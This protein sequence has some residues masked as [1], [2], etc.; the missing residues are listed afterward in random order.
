MRLFTSICL[1][2]ALISTA[3]VIADEDLS[4][5]C[6]NGMTTSY[7]SPT[8][9]CGCASSFSNARK[10][11]SDAV[12][13]KAPTNGRVGCKNKA[14]GSECAA[15]C[16]ETFQPSAD[17]QTCVTKPA[18]TNQTV[19]EN[20]C[21]VTAGNV[22]FLSAHPVRGCVCLPE[23][24]EELFCGGGLAD[25]EADA[26]M[27]CYDTTSPSG[28]REVKCGVKCFN[29]YTP[30][31]KHTCEMIPAES[32]N[33]GSG[34]GSGNSGTNGSGTDNSG[35][36]NSG[37]GGSNSVVAPQC[38]AGLTVSYSSPSKPC[39]CAASF[40]VVIK[41]VPDAVYCT[42]PANGLAACENLN[43]GSGSQCTIVCEPTFE[44]T[45][46]GKQ[47]QAGAGSGPKSE[48][49]CS[50]DARDI[51]YLS[52]DPVRGCVCEK[53]LNDATFCGY[54]VGDPESEAEMMCHDTTDATGNREV[55]CGVQCFN[56][57]VA[58]DKN[59]CAAL[60]LTGSQAGVG[61]ANGRYSIIN[62]ENG[63]A[64][65]SNGPK[66]ISLERALGKVWDLKNTTTGIEMSYGSP[67]R[68]ITKLK[69]VTVIGDSGPGVQVL[70][71][72]DAPGWHFIT[73][74]VAAEPPIV[75][76]SLGMS[77]RGFPIYANIY[78]PRQEW[79]F[80]QAGEGLP[81]GRY[82]IRNWVKGEDLVMTNGPKPV[83]LE[84]NSGKTWD[85]LNTADG[86]QISFGSPPR[87]MQKLD[88]NQPPAASNSPGVQ[89]KPVPNSPGVYFIV[90]DAAT[91]SPDTLTANARSTTPPGWSRLDLNNRYSKWYFVRL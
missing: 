67:P 68:Y 78:R 74:D 58:K 63:D 56:D 3:S 89:L 66:S 48:F 80:A 9:F 36:G 21:P 53:P 71:V 79:S 8:T 55:K 65:F 52:A 54:P 83:E 37:G 46:D 33:S 39:G 86:I 85:V 16:E 59:T 2:S 29:G 76:T 43:T 22:G 84:K 23:L 69:G 75:L 49:D 77:C 90:D 70:P 61:L 26:E 34:A 12:E 47:C 14:T 45:A 82:Y 88:R 4:P 38:P 28:N 50:E 1:L 11:V 15:R 32:P 6:P 40:N 30:K 44:P 24:N 42:P 7:S 64:L 87:Y 17:G 41:R 13:C 18:A 25:A 20:D 35:I 57:Y 60:P 91:N 27:M 10:R 81:N 5:P 73:D 62:R 51:S 19:S 31:D 72:P